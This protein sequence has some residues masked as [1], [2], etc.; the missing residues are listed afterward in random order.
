M[1]RFRDFRKDTDTRDNYAEI[2]LGADDFIYPYF[3]VDG[4]DIVEA[5]PGIKGAY[6][7]SID[8]LIT[9]LEH[10]IS[11][12]IKDII[13]F[14]LVDTSLKD[15]TAS[16]AYA[17]ENLI[18][19]AVKAIKRHYSSVKVYTDVCVCAYMSHGHC[20][21]VRGGHINNDDTLPLLARTAVSHAL[22][23][24][25]FVVPSAM[26]DGQVEVIRKALNQ[27]GK[28]STR[29][30]SSGVK[31]SS[32]FYTPF[33]EFTGIV[34]TQGDRQTYQ[35][36]FRTNQ[37]AL[38]EAWSDIA[39]GADSIL[40]SPAHTYL[41][42]IS[43]IKASFPSTNVS[44]FHTSGEYMTIVA[45]AQAGIVHEHAA[46][47]EILTAIKRAGANKIISYYAKIFMQQQFNTGQILY[48]YYI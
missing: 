36:D 44:A 43:K 10:T 21:V 23:G 27:H 30:L 20:G 41:D 22:A 29:I 28:Y 48:D 14:G 8:Q 9:D 4:Q 2:R 6:K 7:M 26:M 18:A 13:L 11:L 45:A 1:L 46:L 5:I 25:D 31:Y 24:A 32:N 3:V 16:A 34:P 12:G 33:R 42:V 39:E 47:N 17:D 37:Q 35:I 15:N 40:V 19:R 38:G